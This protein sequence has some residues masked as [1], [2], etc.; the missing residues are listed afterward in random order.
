[1]V[2]LKKLRKYDE[3][4]YNSFLSEIVRLEGFNWAMHCVHRNHHMTSAVVFRNTVQG[5]DYWWG[6]ISRIETQKVK[7][8]EKV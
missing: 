4:I 8:S 7:N 5:S 2:R 6:V 3:G 1:M